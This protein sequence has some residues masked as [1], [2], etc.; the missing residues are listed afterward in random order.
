MLAISHELRSPLTR[1]K[2]ALEFL[3]DNSIRQNLLEDIE[4][5]ERLITDILESEALNTR[6]ASLRR[7]EA[8][9]SG[10]VRSI[11]ETDFSH[12]A[13]RIEFLAPTNYFA[14]EFD[15][16][17]IR[18]LL[19]NLLENALRYSPEEGEPVRIELG[20]Q[21]KGVFIRVT[22]HGPGIP[23][24]HLERITEPFYRADPARSRHT[25]G[26]GLGLYL[27]RRIAEAH[28]GE[29]L[30]RSQPG[31]GAEVTAVLNADG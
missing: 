29:L 21:G 9:L 15:L 19:R 14:G 20:K 11:L 6:H 28:G 17:R 12:Q 1:S 24:E 23:A 2:V 10:I 16:T 8:E 31:Q 7:E 22:D 13:H 26:F 25:G 18:L 4:E 27:C 5:M 3:E 30:I